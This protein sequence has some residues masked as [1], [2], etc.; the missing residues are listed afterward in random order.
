M[1]LVAKINLQRVDIK[2]RVTRCNFPCNLSCNVG[3]RSPLQVAGDILHAAILGCNLQWFQ[4]KSLQPLQKVESSSTASFTMCDFLCNLCCIGVA[5]QVA[6]RL[7]SVTCPL[8]NLSHSFSELATI[9]KSKAWYP[10]SRNGRRIYLRR[11][12][13][14]YFTA[15]NT[16]ITSISFER[17]I[18]VIITTIWRPCHVWKA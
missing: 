12:F 13:K 6:G 9:A 18:L 17:S 10:Y 8:G 14:E 1:C 11:C 15:Y 16:S 4:E 3:K 7:P 2:A 5:R